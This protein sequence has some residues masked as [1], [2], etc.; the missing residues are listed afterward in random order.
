MGRLNVDDI[1]LSSQANSNTSWEIHRDEDN[2]FLI[3]HMTADDPDV[4]EIKGGG[5]EYLH[6]YF[7]HPVHIVGNLFFDGGGNI[8]FVN[9]SIDGGA[10]VDG[11]IGSEKIADPEG[12]I[13]RLRDG[14]ISLDKLDTSGGGFSDLIADG[15][16][17]LSKLADLSAFGN[18]LPNGSIPASKIDGL[19]NL[20][21]YLKTTGGTMT[22]VI[23]VNNGKDATAV[24]NKIKNGR[25]NICGGTAEADGSS[26]SLYGISY[27]T[28]A[29]RGKFE[30]HSTKS[31]GTLVDL[32]GKPNGTLTWDG[33]PVITSKTITKLT[34][35][36]LKALTSA[37]VAS[38]VDEEGNPKG[39]GIGVN[40]DGKL[41]FDANNMS[42]EVFKNMLAALSLPYYLENKEVYLYVDQNA[43]EDIDEV[44]W[45]KRYIKSYYKATKPFKSIEKAVAFA[46]SRIS[47]GTK[48]GWIFLK[49]GSYSIPSTISLTQYSTNGGAWFILPE[50]ETSNV[51]LET[52]RK[53]TSSSI[54]TCSGGTWYLDYMKFVYTYTATTSKH[55]FPMILASS[56]NGNLYLR[57]ISFTYN[58]N[59]P[60]DLYSAARILHAGSGSA[61]RFYG[62]D[63]WHTNCGLVTPIW[64]IN[65][66]NPTHA[67]GNTV[68]W[69][70]TGSLVSFNKSGKASDETSTKV[71]VRGPFNTFYN[72]LYSSQC[73]GRGS[74]GFCIRFIGDG[75]DDQG[76]RFSLTTGSSIG[77][78]TGGLDD[79][80]GR[81]D[82]GIT[83]RTFFPG[84]IDGAWDTN[85]YCWIY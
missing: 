85:T 74:D 72:G 5:D 22:G 23:Q 35:D 60:A 33:E 69:C 75:T 48:N 52:S 41:V 16:I 7:Y 12:I 32:V 47:L 55:Y 44:D 20:S 81:P 11:S 6:T 56:G 19:N 64:Q 79:G 21:Y 78:L 77:N 76:K 15:S 49:A 73:Q 31:D 13:N 2:N 70:E 14:S 25:L 34:T 36:Q 66:E 26:L 18:A 9:N 43:E 71:Y 46:T 83:T 61:M 65:K 24:A 37:M 45:E 80:E 10:I 63:K 39:G 1:V 8:S 54:F 68:I 67:G 4:M 38:G 84:S 17:T 57:N 30:L 51:T 59:T 27:A 82:Y 3:R 53:D 50:S 62:V 58:D 42:T 29:D 28:A 40:S